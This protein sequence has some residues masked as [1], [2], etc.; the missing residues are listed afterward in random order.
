M[1]TIAQLLHYDPATFLQVMKWLILALATCFIASFFFSI[2]YVTFYGVPKVKFTFRRVIEL[3][4]VVLFGLG[5]IML[6]ERILDVFFVKLP[7]YETVASEFGWI[8]AFLL[9]CLVGITS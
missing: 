8:T 4:S 2:I 7:S 5:L 3:L 6:L 9:A 1:E